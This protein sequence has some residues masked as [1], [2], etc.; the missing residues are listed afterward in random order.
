M[1]CTVTSE[2]LGAYAD[3]ELAGA[4][5]E[6]L[7]DHIEHCVDCTRQLAE[8][9]RLTSVLTGSFMRY[10]APDT[11][12]ARVRAAVMADVEAS[13]IAGR[14]RPQWY[15][16]AAAVVVTAILT[17]S[18]TYAVA[19]RGFATRSTTD[20]IMAAHIRSLMAGHL[21]DVASDAHHQV[22]PWFNGRVDVSPPVPNLDSLGFPLVGG[23]L[24]VVGDRTVAVVVYGRR[25]H[26]INVFA[27]PGSS[28]AGDA[29]TVSAE[30][31]YHVVR[32]SA[33]GLDTWAISDLNIGELQQF[34]A[35]LRS[36][37]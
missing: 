14:V 30:R 22:K 4:D 2:R 26:K 12:R 27:R 16:L 5:R 18:G 28:A 34:V 3:N 36:A 24:D 20:A 29:P 25:Q 17:A 13:R 31:G 23:R 35:A 15:R 9:A 21:T 10:P 33:S 32:W 37:R 11:L 1:A 8:Y 19:S 6:R 7:H